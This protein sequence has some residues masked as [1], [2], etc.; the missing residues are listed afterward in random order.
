MM[1]IIETVAEMRDKCAAL[2]GP[3]GFVPTM[4]YLHRGHISLIDRARAECP[5][6]VVSIFVNPSQFLPGED[7]ERY[8]RDMPRDLALCEAAGVSA[9]FAP[10]AA[11][12]Y[13]AGFSTS[14]EVTGLQDRWEGSIR[15]GHFRG[16]ATVVAR[17]FRIVQAERAY[18][19]EK[20][21]QQLQVV[22]RMT[23]DLCLD[24][25]VIG[26][27]TI[28]EEDGLA[29]SSRNVYLEAGD[30]QRATALYR[31][32]LAAQRLVDE[33]E[34]DGA[35][36][37]AAMEAVVLGEGLRLDYAIAV[38]PD[39]LEP[40]ERVDRTARALIAARLGPVR[41]IDNAPLTPP[42]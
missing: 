5:S 15:P 31:A 39:S 33:G 41:L 3:L 35:T 18:F 17:L 13:P 16:V 7:Y 1:Q 30:R 32:L 20:D 22:R 2:A 28:R 12:M 27:P 10:T 6:A 25:E 4:G 8:P 14:V 29:M 26:S 40:L 34:S 38:D 42:T 11:E 24:T 37:R 9:V 21:Y 36:I 19:G 23:S